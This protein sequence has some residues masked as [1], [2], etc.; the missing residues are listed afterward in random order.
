MPW[1]KISGQQNL[2]AN[3]LPIALAAGESF[4]LPQGQGIVGQFGGVAAPQLATNNPLT[5]Q[6]I[7]SLG[8]Y[9]VLQVYDSNLNYW[10]T[11]N[12][13][14]MASI[15]ISADGQNFRV[16]NSTGCPVGA[17]I[18]TNTLGVANGFY[19]Y[20]SQGVAQ[21]IVNGYATTGNS[22]FT[23]T[24]SAGGSL[25]NSIVGGAINTT[26]SFSG[27]VYSGNLGV[28]GTFGATTG[29]VTASA[30]SN[31]T[32]TPIIVF[33]P[34]PNQGQQPY[35]LPTA[36][37]TISAG[38]IASVT[39][40]GQ[41]AGLLGLPGITVVPAPGDTTGSG[42]VLGWIAAND[43]M[44]GSGLLT[45]MWPIF[46][47]TAL[48]AV[49]TFT[50]SPSGPAATAIMNFTIT[51]FGGSAG[52]GYG[53][54]P[55]GI[56]FGGIVAGTAALANPQ[57]DKGLSIPIPPPIN[58]AT[59]TGVPSL[60][61]PFGGVNFQAVPSYVA[62]PNGTAAPT[63]ANTNTCTVGGASDTFYLSSI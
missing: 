41:G 58:V 46:Y 7:V 19:G 21:T 29:G 33:T 17:I 8:Q 6:Y 60:A 16:A 24:P 26:I 28:N 9:S 32:R 31:Y 59:G 13:S 37:C 27:T 35:I 51:A 43:S 63:T 3:P 42:A 47:G 20:T 34:P 11:V 54:T 12:V 23:I 49:P 40:I 5:G 36:V 56:I 18:T 52:V 1:N 15:P 45:A 25:W 44:V 2:P 10:R 14:P 53:T 4:L 61:G 57:Y 55:G 48:T 50:F 62:I 22:V 39:V 30:G 38:A